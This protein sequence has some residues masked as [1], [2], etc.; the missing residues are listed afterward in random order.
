MWRGVLGPL[1]LTG[2]YDNG[3]LLLQTGTE[4]RLILTNTFFCL[5]MQQKATWV[6]PGRDTGTYWIISSSGGVTVRTCWRQG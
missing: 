6:H 2:F 4:H 1:G 5:L 3:L